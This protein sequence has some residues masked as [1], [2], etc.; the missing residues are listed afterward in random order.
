[1]A[2]AQH[3]QVD[4]VQL[5]NCYRQMKLIREF[6]REAARQYTQGKIQGFLHLYSGEEAVAVGAISALGPDDYIVTHYRDHGHAIARGVETTRI[7]AE[8]FGKA[9][10]CSRGRGGSMHL[11]DASR[12]FLGGYAIVG[13]QMPVAVGLGLAAQYRGEDRLALCIFGDGALNEG[14]FHEAMNLASVWHLPVVF[15]CENNLYGM[16]ASAKENLALFDAIYKMSAAYRIPGYQVDGNDVLAVRDLM[17]RSVEHVR[18]GKGPVFIEAL[19]Y[20]LQGHSIADAGRYRPQ[21][22]V[23]YWAAR[24]PIPRFQGWLLA[25]RLA[26]KEELE[27]INAGVMDEVVKAAE[28]AE[29]S[30]F[31]AP[32][33]LYRFVYK[34]S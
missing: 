4:K 30:P 6:E 23:A 10:G 21:E 12:H 8:L 17:L 18:D 7:M 11:F 1:M 3:Q 32:E 2:I 15:L 20:R 27:N 5:L 25:E 13:G 29:E 16:G 26:T 19:T 31:P 14:E 28:F 34:E 24:D 33:E 9:T 22:E